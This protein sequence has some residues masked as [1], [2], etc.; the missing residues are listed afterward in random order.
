MLKPACGCGSIAA[1]RT[2]R[3]FSIT[4]CADDQGAMPNSPSAAKRMR[5]DAKRRMRN[6]VTKK[7]IKT[8]TK[9]TY[10]VA[11]RQGFRPGPGR[12]KAAS[13][14]I[15]KAGRAGFS[16]PTRPLAAR[17]S[18]PGPTPRR[19]Q[20]RS[21]RE[22][23][24]QSGARC[25]RRSGR[26]DAAATLLDSDFECTAWMPASPRGIDLVMP[27]LEDAFPTVRAALAATVRRPSRSDREPLDPFEAM[28]AVLLERELG[29]ARAAS[30][31]STRSRKPACSPP[32][33]WPQADVLEIRDTLLE[34]GVSA[35][36]QR[37][38]AA[39][40]TSPDGSSSITAAGSNRLFNPD[41]STDWLRGELAAIPRHR[42]G[43]RRRD[44][45]LC[46]RAAVVSGRPGD[47]SGAG[48]PRLARSR[49]RLRRSP[50]SAGRP[51]DRSEARCRTARRANG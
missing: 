39:Q 29:A 7:V 10:D 17:A 24:S 22:A 14:K 9:R 41:R 45:A 5:Q 8:L 3:A 49:R 4:T 47:V 36:P 15:D 51:R 26:R 40:A 32:I 33:A 42:P 28:V 2:G 18:W 25:D 13:S 31:R 21:R 16:I 48:S 35:A 6:R 46:P 20:S 38:G 23:R 30:P 44:L 27:T 37:T 19:W 1:W 50:R 12:P 34:H 11:G 43:R